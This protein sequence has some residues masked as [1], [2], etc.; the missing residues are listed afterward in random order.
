MI[1]SRVEHHFR[2]N[3]SSPSQFH[4]KLFRLRLWTTLVFHA[5]YEQRRSSHVIHKERWR[6]SIRELVELN[7]LR[8][9]GVG[10]RIIPAVGSTKMR[11]DI[12]DR[13][14]HN[15]SANPFTLSN[16]IG[17]HETSIGGSTDRD[18]VANYPLNL[19]LLHDGQMLRQIKFTPF[20]AQPVRELSAIT[21]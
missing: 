14:A 8:I 13:S 10:V 6:Q 21:A 18:A 15:G 3:F 9:Y 16:A 12:S 11:L 2:L 5:L 19:Q 17:C 20:A 7:L 4:I 1:S